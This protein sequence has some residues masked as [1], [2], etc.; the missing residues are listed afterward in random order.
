[1]RK[2]TRADTM[3]TE[4]TYPQLRHKLNTKWIKFRS[5]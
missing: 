3:I 4:T 1:M 5:F 2:Q